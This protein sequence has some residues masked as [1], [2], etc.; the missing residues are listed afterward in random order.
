MLAALGT[1]RKTKVFAKNSIKEDGPFY[2]I[3]C[4]KEVVLKKGRIKVHHFAHKPPFSCNRGQGETEKH[5][6]CKEAIY[7]KLLMMPN[8]NNV[9]VEH[10]L[11]SSVADIYAV[12]N[13]VPVAIEVQRSILSVN[14]II[15]RTKE[16]E[17]LG[18][19][20]LWVSLFSDRLLEDRFS[21]TAWEK[22]C[23]AV[24]Y[25]RVYYWKSDLDLVPYHFDE[26]KLYVEESTW[27]E[28]GGNERSS[29]GYY[30]T[31][32]RYKTP[33]AGQVVN[34]ARDFSP[35][36]K[37]EWSAKS[38]YIPACRIYLDGQSAWWGK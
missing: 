2:C 12:I 26:Y 17:R 25:G 32:R 6:E 19:H 28:S 18:I 36:R 29:G 16:Y 35:K 7:K 22:W 21:P 31:S 34:I 20:V 30:R 8:V 38:I 27:Y 10:D 23:H 37:S 3:G 13:N 4:K 15:R 9:D 14:E 5:R 24:Y 11:G 33:V 1:V